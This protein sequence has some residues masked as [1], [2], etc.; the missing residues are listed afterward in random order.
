MGIPGHAASNL[1]GR[2]KKS[3]RQKA[4]RFLSEEARAKLQASQLINRLQ[5][6]ALGKAEYELSLA[7]IRSIEVLLR[8][9]VPDLVQTEI[10]AQITHRYVVEMPA[11]LSDEEWAEK[12]SGLSIPMIDLKQI[13]Q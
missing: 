5:K 4:R 3:D 6:F 12:Y 9:C 1:S 7:E 8:K 13:K 2:I 11:S 10:A